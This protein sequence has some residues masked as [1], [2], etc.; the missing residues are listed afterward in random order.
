MVCHNGEIN[1]LQ[2]NEGGDYD[3]YA[4]YTYTSQFNGGSAKV[5]GLE[6]AYQQQFTFLPGIFQ[7]LGAYAN[8]SRNETEGDYGGTVTTNWL[9]AMR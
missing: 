8:Y 1:T 5:R 9:R 4:G 2:G 3:Q 7:G 6:L